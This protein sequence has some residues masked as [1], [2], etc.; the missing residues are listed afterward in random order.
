MPHG[1]VPPGITVFTA[2]LAREFLQASAGVNG[3]S[4]KMFF[5]V[6]YILF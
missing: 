6:L 3:A 4:Q 1:G 2:C 5:L